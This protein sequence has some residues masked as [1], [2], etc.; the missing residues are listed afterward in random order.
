[1]RFFVTGGTGFLGRPLVERLRARGEVAV[2]VKGDAPALPR[3]VEAVEGD[4]L[5]PSSLAPAARADVVF[6][7]AAQA[8]PQR[9]REDPLATLEANVGGTLNLARAAARGRARVVLTSTAQV[10][11]DPGGAPIAEAHRL[12]PGSPYA[13]SKL[14]AEGVLRAG[15]PGRSV[16]LRLFNAY[17]PGQAEHYVVARLMRQL[18]TRGQATMR[19]SAPLRDFTYVGDVVEAM[20]RAG[21]APV[22][23]EVLNIGSGTGVRVGELAVLAAELA[24]GS[25]TFESDA[26]PAGEVAS[27][28]ADNAKARKQLGW[29]PQVALREGL[30]RTLAAARGAPA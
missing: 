6:H 24:G 7:L 22:G 8:S 21:E 18:A 3:G 12:E 30:A 27:L 17:G 13:V 25:V 28:V 9:S 16:V 19:S 15:L 4:V 1:M 26:L 10:Y 23:G 5:D 11:A 14:A 20:V 29:A 2:L